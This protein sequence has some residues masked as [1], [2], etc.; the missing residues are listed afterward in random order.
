[1]MKRLFIGLF[2]LLTS[3]AW[4]DDPCA[5]IGKPG[6]Y[7]PGG[8]CDHGDVFGKLTQIGIPDRELLAR[9]INNQVTQQNEIAGLRNDLKTATDRLSAAVD[10]LTKVSVALMENNDKWQ[11]ATLNQTINSINAMPEKL[12]EEKLLQAV[13]VTTIKEQL[14]KD[15][16]FLDS[17]TKLVKAK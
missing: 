5:A 2:F 6:T 4:A 12:A 7:N 3:N 13:L 1:M 17:V 14:V 10:A 11:K 8:T 9:M 16:G 15:A